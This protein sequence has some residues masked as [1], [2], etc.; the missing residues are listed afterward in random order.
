MCNYPVQLVVHFT[1]IGSTPW[2][3]IIGLGT[4]SITTMSLPKSF[5]IKGSGDE[6]STSAH[7]V[8]ILWIHSSLVKEFGFLLPRSGHV[9]WSCR[10]AEGWVQSSKSL[11]ACLIRPNIIIQ[12]LIGTLRHSSTNLQRP[13]PTKWAN[14]SYYSLLSFTANCLLVMLPQWEPNGLCMYGLLAWLLW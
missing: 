10:L 11:H 13:V 14:T 2:G 3:L 8:S 12:L 9:Y 1:V 5:C 4:R 6:T 7:G